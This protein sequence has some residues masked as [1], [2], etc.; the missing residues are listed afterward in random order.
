[1]RFSRMGALALGVAAALTVVVVGGAAGAAGETSAATAASPRSITV[2]GSGAALSVPNRAAFSFGVTTQAKSASAALNGNN[3]EM[4]KVIDA[5]K[6]AGVAARD[7][8]TSSVSL[9]PRYSAERRGHRRLHGVQHRQCDDQEHL[10]VGRRYR[11]GR[12]RGGQPGL[13]A[14]VHALRRDGALPA[15]SVGGRRERARQG[16]DARR[17]EQGAAG[18]RALDRRV[19]GRPD[20]ARR[21]GGGCR[22]RN[23]HRAGHAAHRGLRDGG[24]RSPRTGLAERCSC[25]GD[26]GGTVTV[27]PDPPDGPSLAQGHHVLEEGLRA[28][29]GYLDRTRADDDPVRNPSR[30]LRRGRESRC[31][32][33]G[34]AERARRLARAADE[35]VRLDRQRV[36]RARRPGHADEVEP[37]VRPSPQPVAAAR[38]STSVR[39]A[40]CDAA[41]GATPR[42]GRRR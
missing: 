29:L 27:S 38:R 17:C 16:A 41:R 6:R 42:A 15:R 18:R 9:S 32:S 11:R 25:R 26:P 37:A 8:Q 10:A 19:L 39:P 40:G 35:V 3:T 4:R 21:E 5:I 14:V 28:L 2:T 12:G 23:A 33:R 22:C 20:P 1:M 30:R 36:T 13:R 7:V 34:R 24:V 31:R